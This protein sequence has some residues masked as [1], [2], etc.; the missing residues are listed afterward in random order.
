MHWKQGLGMYLGVAWSTQVTVFA[1]AHRNEV[2]LVDE[3]F[4]L[5]FLDGH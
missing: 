4:T 2:K 3:V 5:A 1:C